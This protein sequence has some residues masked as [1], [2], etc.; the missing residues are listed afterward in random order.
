MIRALGV[1]CQIQTCRMVSYTEG[2]GTS[3]SIAILLLPGMD[4]SGHLLTGLVD[5]L[6][7]HRPVRVIS[8][9]NSEPLTYDELTTFVLERTPDSRFVILGES[10]SGP[11]AIEV[12]ATEPRVAGLILASSFARHPMPTL[13][14]PLARMIDLKWVPARIVVAAL[15]G[16]ARK[17][18]LT[19]SLGRVLA[20][21]PREVVR[22]RASEVLRVD[23]RNRLRAV[24]C[25]MLCLH[26]RF[27]R[28]VRKKYLDEVTS[29]NPKCEVRMFDAP[30]M[31]L[32]T[33]AA[34]A[35]TAINHFCNQLG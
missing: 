27:D 34:E 2:M 1:H 29:S 18:D 26:G 31:L 15:L 3:D 14:V 33:H 32:Q 6:A 22:A 17:P 19:E 16:S 5:R 7:Q 30:H 28:L 8:Y 24:T 21:L 23:K 11:I 13:F 35:A 25:P 10:F 4:G 9:P 12:A 20:K